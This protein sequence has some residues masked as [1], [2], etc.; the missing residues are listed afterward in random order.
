[1]ILGQKDCPCFGLVLLLW[2]DSKDYLIT[3]GRAYQYFKV[4]MVKKDMHIEDEYMFY[5]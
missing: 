2:M 3:V 5:Q 4:V 1:M